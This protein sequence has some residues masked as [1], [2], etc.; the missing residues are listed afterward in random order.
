MTERDESSS[1]QWTEV[2]DLLAKLYAIVAR[3]EALFCDR[4]FTPDGHLVGSIG[5]VIAAH[6]FTLELLPAG[7]RVHDAETSDGRKV[8][9]K[10]TQGKKSVGVRAEPEYL[11]VLCLTLERCVDV[12]YNGPGRAPWSEP[13]KVQSNGQKS[14]SLKRLREL[15]DE[16]PDYE[17]L[18]CAIPCLRL[19]K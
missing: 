5:E 12:V 15:D 14:I 2:G 11:L 17:R 7:A 4:K 9:I 10:F 1:D 13:G 19:G 8:Q 16:V 18:R 3:L 6:M